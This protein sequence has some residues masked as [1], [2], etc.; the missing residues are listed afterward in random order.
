MI[1]NIKAVL[2]D[3][4]GVF[5]ASPFTGM[6]KYAESL[7]VDSKTLQEQVFGPYEQDTDHPWHR[8]ERGEQTMDATSEELATL[9][10][11]S[12]ID[13][14]TLDG[15]FQSM[16][17][18]ESRRLDEIGK[19]ADRSAV[20]EMVRKLKEAGIRNAIITNNIAEFREA[21]RKMIPVDELFEEVVDSSAEGIRKP[22]PAI[23]YLALER[24]GGLSPQDAVFLDDAISNVEA[25]RNLGI[26]GIHVKDDPT[27]AMEELAQVCGL[28]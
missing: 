7:G 9:A 27:P 14:F 1:A 25:A 22:N 20:V 21:W 28:A 11:N 17:L 16:R 19:Q 26:Y 2:W 8:L 18:D 23:Y 13:G 10:E 3:F 15:F 6:H 24:L 12:G 4:G 5:T